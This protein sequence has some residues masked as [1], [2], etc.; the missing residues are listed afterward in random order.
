LAKKLKKC[1]KY[2]NKSTG[3]HSKPLKSSVTQF[4]DLQIMFTY[5]LSSDLCF[6]KGVIDFGKACVE[7][8]LQQTNTQNRTRL[9]H[10]L[11]TRIQDFGEKKRGEN[12]KRLLLS[13]HVCACVCVRACVRACVLSAL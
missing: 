4:Q 2:P 6:G 7:Q 11:L 12:V 10:F 5:K 9:S 3:T 1:Q 13:V 8:R